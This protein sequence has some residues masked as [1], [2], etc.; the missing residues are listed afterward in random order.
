MD[1]DFLNIY[2]GRHWSEIMI[3]DNPFKPKYEFRLVKPNDIITL[4]L[5]LN[6]VNVYV[7]D[8]GIIQEF[9]VG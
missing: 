1:I 5:H 9:D 7:D 4:D 3:E 6:R 8:N 2:V